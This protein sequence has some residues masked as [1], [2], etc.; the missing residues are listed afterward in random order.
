MA[1]AEKQEGEQDLSM[2]EILQSIRKIIAEEGEGVPAE[3][4][5]GQGDPVPGSDVLELTDD[6]AEEPAEETA[7]PAAS[8]KPEE[9][10][11]KDVLQ[12]IDD[13]LTPKPPA[14][15]IAADEQAAADAEDSLLSNQAASA[16]AGA[17]K[18]ISQ[19]KPTPPPIPSP[20][21]RNGATV[22]DLVIECIRPML[23]DWLDANLPTV[24]ER[25]VE[26]EVRKLAS[27]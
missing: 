18:K 13:A 5:S 11:P 8:A 27:D 26:K 25:I 21:L 17:L 3:P 7:S 14:D 23:K 12:N 20:G 9:A 15:L 10:E 4:T 2:E 6:M 22:E 24:V 19:A 1:S 16:S